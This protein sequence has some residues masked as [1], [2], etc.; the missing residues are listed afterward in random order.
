VDLDNFAGTILS[1][2]SSNR[3]SP[4]DRNFVNVARFS[5]VKKLSIFIIYVV[6]LRLEHPRMCEIF[7]FASAW[8]FVLPPHQL[9]ITA[10]PIQLGLA[11]VRDASR[12]FTALD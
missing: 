12:V 1:A 11:N 7:E 3:K 6:G 10:M 8:F 4:C 2:N 9:P 5:S